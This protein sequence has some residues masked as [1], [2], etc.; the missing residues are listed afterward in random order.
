MET[1]TLHIRRQPG[2]TAAAAATKVIVDGNTMA[3]LRVGGNQDLVLPRKT[4]S[5]VLLTQVPLGKDIEKSFTIDP[6]DSQDVTLLF[7]YKFNAK[8]LIPF[9]AFTQQQ[10]YIETEVIHG[11]SVSSNTTA[12][13]TNTPPQSQQFTSEPSSGE[14]KYCTNCG[15]P[16][17]KSAKFCEQCGN[18]F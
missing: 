18:K 15:K 11:P 4:V 16:N 10:A 5:I 12:N 3:S 13:S 7:T 6:G 9:G 2:F 14:I 17:P 1:F 8:S